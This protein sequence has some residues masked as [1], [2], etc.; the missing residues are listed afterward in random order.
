[1]IFLAWA[2]AI[3]ISHTAHFTPVDSSKPW[4]SL[5]QLFPANTARVMQQ[6]LTTTNYSASLSM[7]CIQALSPILESSWNVMA[8]GD[9]W[10]GKWRGNWRMEWVAS[11]LHTTSELGVSSIT[12]ADAHNSA[13]SSRLNWRPR[14]FKLTRPFRRKTKSGFCACAIILIFQMQSPSIMKWQGGAF[15]R[16]DRCWFLTAGVRVLCRV[17]G[18]ENLFSDFFG[19]SP[20][21]PHYT[22]VPYKAISAL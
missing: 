12:I 11:T 20:A 16:E 19:P 22:T 6:I 2:E 17:N 5:S 21:N 7:L 15:P 10:E 4:Q 1:M 13:A 3:T 14:Q 18:G 8:H 9:A